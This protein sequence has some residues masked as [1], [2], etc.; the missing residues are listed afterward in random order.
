MKKLLL[1]LLFSAS[2]VN[3]APPEGR[4]R[5][6]YLALSAKLVVEAEV[7]NVERAP[8]H[9]DE[10]G[11]NVQDVKY[12]VVKV[13]KGETSATE[14]V[15]GFRIEFGVPFVELKNSRLS[16][17]L[18]VQG[19]RHVLFLKSDP[20]TQRLT[21]SRLDDKLQRYMR[22]ADHYGLAVADAETLS[23]LQQVT[24]GTLQEDQKALRQFARDAELVVVAEISEVRPS[25]NFWSGFVRSTQSVDYRAIEVLKGNL[26][27]PEL[28]LEF[29]LI[30]GSPFVD[31]FEPHLLSEVFKPG[32]RQV[33]FLKRREKGVYFESDRRKFESFSDF[34]HLWSTPSD[35]NTL[36]YLRQFI[37]AQANAPRY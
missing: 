36:N 35:P 19:R 6:N 22:P 4:D 17:E 15:V 29:L 2:I 1:L 28:R 12:K 18:F 10:S 5:I 26:N 13:F 34:D 11:A 33:H 14:F 3:A 31:P 8:G 21:E 7:L 25:L 9:E 16:P 37:F 27:H 23:Q 30:Q 24:A 32:T 20:A